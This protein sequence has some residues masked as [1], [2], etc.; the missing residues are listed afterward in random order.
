MNEKGARDPFIIMNT[1]HSNK[2][3][4]HWWSFLDLHSKKEIFLFGSFGFDGFKEF[5]LQGNKKILNKIFYGIKK[6]EKK[7]S[8]ITVIILTFSMEEYEKIKNV[9]RFSGTTQEILRLINEF[10]KK[11]NL[12]EEVRIHFVDDQLQKTETDTCGVFQLYSFVNLFNPDEN[13]AIIEDKTLTKKTMEKLF[14]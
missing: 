7:D 11:H 2:I 12:K 8:K 5:L 9:N 14:K 10:G 1:D 13:S 3:G 4:M 6:I